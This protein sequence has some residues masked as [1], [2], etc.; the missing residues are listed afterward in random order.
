MPD[1]PS[2]WSGNGESGDIPPEPRRAARDTA[3]QLQHAS[4]HYIDAGLRP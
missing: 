1:L 4:R 2:M 3:F